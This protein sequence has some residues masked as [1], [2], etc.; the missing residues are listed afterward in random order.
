MARQNKMTLTQFQPPNIGTHGH[1][2]LAAKILLLAFFT[3]TKGPNPA[4]RDKM[5]SFLWYRITSYVKE[6]VVAT[7]TKKWGESAK[8]IASPLA[9]RM[10]HSPMEDLTTQ[11]K[12][13]NINSSPK[14][15][16]KKANFNLGPHLDP[17]LHLR[18]GA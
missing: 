2:S 8:S 18:M 7:R 14:R 13:G 5:R 4:R 15:N 1:D 16:S 17:T 9:S 3:R 6:K 11:F 10:Q 12:N